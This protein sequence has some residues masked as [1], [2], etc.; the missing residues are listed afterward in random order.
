[1]LELTRKIVAENNIACL[2]ITHNIP[3]DRS[4]GNRTIMMNN[5]SIVMELAG[6]ERKN[7]TTEALLKAF[8]QH[9]MSNDRVLF[10]AE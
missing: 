6:E 10:S 3:Y 8:H 1:M 2:M 7:M 5:G 4:I 9:G